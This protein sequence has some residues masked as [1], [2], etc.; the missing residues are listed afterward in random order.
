MC[1]AAAQTGRLWALMYD[2]S[3]L[4]AGEIRSVMMNDYNFLKAT[5]D[6]RNHGLYVR[7]KGKPLVVV[8]GVGFND[9]RKYSLEE[10]D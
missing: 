2:L 10:C 5:Y 7:H 4:N 1:N 3:G 8:W 9:G 6:F